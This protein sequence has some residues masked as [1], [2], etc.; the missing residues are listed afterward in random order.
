MWRYI[1]LFL[2]R[3]RD[4]SVL[5]GGGF[6]VAACAL[7]LLS[8]TTQTTVVQA[9]Q[10]ISQSWRPAYD[11]VVL[12]P[13]AQTQ[14]G[15]AV[16]PDVFEQYGN[17]ITQQ[18]YNT[19]L[20]MSDV[21]VAAPISYIGYVQFPLPRLQFSDKPF[22]PG[23]YRVDTTLTTTN[24]AQQ[25]VERQESTVYY[26]TSACISDQALDGLE[27]QGVFISFPNCDGNSYHLPVQHFL[28]Y[29]QGTYL[30]AAIDPDQEKQLTHIDSAITSG[31]MLNQQ[32]TL[33]AD[34]ANPTITFTY[35]SKTQTGSGPGYQINDAILDNYD[36]P[37]L[38]NVEQPPPT[39]LSV[40]LV[41]L[42]EH[43]N[44]LRPQQALDLGG[45]AYLKQLSALKTL[46]QGPVPLPSDNMGRLSYDLLSWNGNSWRTGNMTNPDAESRARLM[47]FL[48]TSSGK[49][50]APTAA[51]PGQGGSAYTLIPADQQNLGAI[52][53]DPPPVNPEIPLSK[54]QGSQVLFRSLTPLH[55]STLDYQPFYNAVYTPKPVGQFD[56]SALPTDM[57]NV[58]N[59][60]PEGTFSPP[61]TVLRFDANGKPIAPTNLQST[62]NATSSLV[63][64][65]LAFTTLDAAC[66][67]LGNTCISAIRVRIA[68]STSGQN[69]LGRV[70]QVAQ[71]IESLTGLHVQVMIG[72]SPQPTL[73]YVP[74]VQQGQHGAIHAIDP[75]G[76]VEERWIR[77]GAGVIYLS[78]LGTTRELLLYAILAA[79]LGY[80]VVAFSTLVSGQKAEYAILH[81]L[82][83]PPW[84]TIKLF[85]GQALVLAGGGA[86]LGVGLAL[87]LTW[88]L[89][90]VAIWPIV[91]LTLPAILSLAL[92]SAL[93]PLWQ[94]QHI[95]PMTLLRKHSTTTRANILGS[96]ALAR[97]IPL[98]TLVLRNITRSRLRSLLT[99][100]S[101][102]C[103]SAL[104][105]TIGNGILELRQ[106][107]FGTLLGDYILLQTSIPQLAGGFFA[108]LLAFASIANVMI[109]QVR[110]RRQEIGML[111]ALGWRSI[112]I[113]R[114]FLQEG[115][116]LA[117]VGTVPGIAVA[118][119]FLEQQTDVEPGASL[120]IACGVGIAMI[121]VALVSMV[122]AMYT[123]R[124]MQVIEI[125]R[126]E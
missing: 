3:Q 58:L 124:R 21:A 29:D 117:V 98:G 15:E 82:G 50:Y 5:I 126:A 76:W 33:E 93:I 55:I 97:L 77:V 80:L 38:I 62:G 66:K 41:Q 96:H 60:L 74:G 123:I 23:F 103:A 30:L 37:L 108:L 81:A 27:Q 28:S 47:N 70:Q 18:Q 113:Q 94:I 68:G 36:V 99:I 109:I 119:W 63:Q 31:S 17:H 56:S 75:L 89:G 52:A 79:C 95:Q 65:P 9:N 104:L 72:S 13:G 87:L 122:P 57:S 67:L 20:N 6:L 35:K 111:Q 7:I 43:E 48:Y 73:V 19:I 100:G 92:L 125:V 12:P 115:V 22:P 53:L 110:E 42:T 26:Q 16:P 61:P 85:L 69:D 86:L 40:K 14:T 25:F 120:L 46:Y 83:W 102:F 8:A 84:Q 91:L 44:D 105:T 1:F 45:A 51:P 121:V 78:Q 64:S 114:L 4:K 106:T 49:N 118:L 32:A 34:D 116:T 39:H 10:I 24:G 11:L 2:G 112:L 54:T 71:E 59:W 88:L 90:A 101:V 107:L